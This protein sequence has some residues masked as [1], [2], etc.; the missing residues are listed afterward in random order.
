MNIE[1][2]DFEECFGN[3]GANLSKGPDGKY[4]SKET[5]FAWIGW[6][7]RAWVLRGEQNAGPNDEARAAQGL[8]PYNPTAPTDEQWQRIT[9]NGRKAWGGRAPAPKGEPS[10]DQLLA[11]ALELVPNATDE[12]KR[13]YGHLW[14]RLC[15][16]ALARF[17]Y[18][19]SV[20]EQDAKDAQK[21]IDAA[22]QVLNWT[23]AEHRPPI[24]E[25]FPSG[26]MARVRVHALADLHDAVAAI[27]QQGG[28]A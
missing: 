6:R 2:A 5:Y 3:L 19:A 14:I 12:H 18:A 24:R 13:R 17:S 26:R 27:A 22:K 4:E 10:D 11:L 9:E 15:R 7:E 1:Q 20:N 28:D 8:P 23:E 21:L 25:A 16:M